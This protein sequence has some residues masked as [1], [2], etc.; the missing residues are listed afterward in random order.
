MSSAGPVCKELAKN[1]PS[2]LGA[3]GK[4]S[5]KSKPKKDKDKVVSI[6][7]QNKK[8]TSSKLSMYLMRTSKRRN[9]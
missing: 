5:S 4:F 1:P 2:D 8:T 6:S 9:K 7:L 3:D